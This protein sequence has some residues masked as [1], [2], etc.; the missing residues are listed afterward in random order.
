MSAAIGYLDPGTRLRENLTISTD[1]QVAELLFEGQRC[2]GV[3]ALV[4]GRPEEFRGRE[5]IL[6]CGR[7]PFA[8][9]SVARGDRAGGASA[10]AWDR[11]A[12]PRCPASG[13]G[14]RTIR[15]SRWR[16]SSSRMRGSSTTT[17]G[18]TSIPALRY[19]SDL[20]GIPPGDMFTVVTNKTSWHA[21]GEQIGSF[22]VTV[23]KT[24]SETGSGEA[25]LARTGRTSRW[26]I[27]TCCPTSATWS[28]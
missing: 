20:P 14:C 28:G 2:V 8:G 15:R 13:S 7:D 5:I 17:R 25:A 24:Y 3:K 21:V 11:G 22:I 6:S 27:S 19:S 10:G 12:R 23:Y 4:G 9:A 18:G 26:W 16:R 1:T